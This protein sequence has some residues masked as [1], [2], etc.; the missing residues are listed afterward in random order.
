MKHTK[1][2]L[3][4]KDH[5]EICKL[6]KNKILSIN[7][8]RNKYSISPNTLYNILKNNNINLRGNRLIKSQQLEIVKLYNKGFTIT[9]IAKKLKLGK[10]SIIKYLKINNVKTRKT[11]GRFQQKYKVNNTL[12]SKINS[13][14]K[15]QF[16]GLIYSDGSLSKNNKT[17]SIR[18]REDDK[19]YLDNWRIKL[20]KTNKP[21][22]FSYTTSTMTSPLNSKKY[23]IK[24]GTAILDITNQQIYNDAIKIG[25]CPNKTKANISMPK[26]HKKY[27]PYFILGLFEGDGCISHCAKNCNFT[28]ACQSN[29]AKDL[30]NYFHSIGI[31]AYNYSRQSIHIIQVSNK[32]DI[33][34]I[35]NMFYKKPSCVIMKRKYEKYKT[36]IN[37]ISRKTIR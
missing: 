31:K 34:K 16:L 21:L 20:L 10:S 29:M 15:A 9:K 13:K 23:T 4:N 30:Y 24:Y 35:F 11:A 12:L 37:K 19:K 33:I 5:K 6:Y 27:I 7:K 22:Y 1:D 17:I 32:K 2:R 28:I 8:I 25:L 26:I 36:I 3:T 18:L 14:E